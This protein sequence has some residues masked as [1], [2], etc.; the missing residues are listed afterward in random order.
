MSRDGVASLTVTLSGGSGDAD[1]YLNFGSQPDTNRWECR[2]YRY[3]NNEVCS[4]QQP[5]TGDWFIGVRGYSAYS[6][7]SLTY[8]YE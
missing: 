3:G 5:D 7:V 6:D 8:Q 4:I 1:L 2:P